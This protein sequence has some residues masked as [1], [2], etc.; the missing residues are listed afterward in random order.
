MMSMAPLSTAAILVEKEPRSTPITE[1]LRSDEGFCLEVFIVLIM[2]L[3]WFG[4]L[5]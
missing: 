3:L 2:L 4:A 1:G 5:M